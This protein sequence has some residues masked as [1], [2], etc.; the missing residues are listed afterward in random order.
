MTHKTII[1]EKENPW[2]E[3]AIIL[4]DSRFIFINKPSGLAVHGV[5]GDSL[6]LIEQLRALRPQAPYLELAHRLDKETSGCL[7]IAKRKS[8]LRAFQKQ[9]ENRGVDKHYLALVKGEWRGG[10][11]KVNVSLLKTK[12]AQGG[13][14]VDANKNEGK[15][16]VS[17]FEAVEKYQGMTLVRIKIITGRT[18][19]IRVHAKYIGQPIA[20]DTKY[21]DEAF[22]QSLTA[23]G[24]QRLFLHAESIRFT[25][26]DIAPYH[27]TASMPLDLNYV[28]QPLKRMS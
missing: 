18:H 23:A 6:G 21:G 15:R 8:A 16:A 22:N 11:Q 1:D 2:L 7:V 13:W 5:Q 27:I 20:G 28:L 12:L 4:E 17:Y 3:E 14:V 25:L 9:Q 26:P 24:L 10:H 19:Q